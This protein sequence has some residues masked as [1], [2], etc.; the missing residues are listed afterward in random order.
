MNSYPRR[1]GER[2]LQV[3]IAVLWPHA[4]TAGRFFKV[5]PLRF[6]CQAQFSRSSVIWRGSCCSSPRSTFLT[7]STR[8]SLARRGDADLLA[9]AHDKAVREFDLSA[10]ALHHVLAHRRPLIGRAAPDPRQPP[11]V[12]GFERFG[13]ALAGAGDR[14]RRQ[15]I[16]LFE[17][18]ATR[19]ADADRSFCASGPFGTV[20]RAGFGF[21][22]ARG[23]PRLV[24]F[25]NLRDAIPVPRTSGNARY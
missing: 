19:L 24:G 13:I 11:L 20:P 14:F 7:M 16:D 18:V 17:L 2:P 6:L 8:R 15:M 22:P 3:S 10:P 21:A 12:I 23:H 25:P 9:F 4:S 5:R 1:K